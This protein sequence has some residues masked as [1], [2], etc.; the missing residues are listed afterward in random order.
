MKLLSCGIW[1]FRPAEG[2]RSRARRARPRKRDIQEGRWP[3]A[4]QGVSIARASRGS[5]RSQARKEVRQTGELR[6]GW[7]RYRAPCRKPLRFPGRDA[8]PEGIGRAAWSSTGAA[9]WRAWPWS[10]GQ[11]CASTF[12]EPAALVEE[13][14]RDPT[15]L[16]AGR[17]P[18]AP[19]KPDIRRGLQLGVIHHTRSR[20]RLFIG[21]ARW[22]AEGRLTLWVYGGRVLAELLEQP[23]RGGREWSEDQAAHLVVVWAGYLERLRALHHDAP[24]GALLYALCIRWRLRRLRGQFLTFSIHPDYVSVFRDFDW[25]APPYQSKHTR[26]RC[27][28]VRAADSKS[29]P[30]GHGVVPKS[31]SGKKDEAVVMLTPTSTRTSA[32]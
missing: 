3:P 24:A 15:A 14:R 7:L 26:K 9:A 6:L 27:A 17:H 22:S 25:L 20:N 11:R 19:F 13:S 18:P 32:G 21:W 28:P 8:D 30:A 31:A 12:R 16:G 4:V 2:A 5:S 29:W 1:P 23:L 10:S